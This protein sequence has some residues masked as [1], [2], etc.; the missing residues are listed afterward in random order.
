VL[1]SAITSYGNR[2]VLKPGCNPAEHTIVYLRGTQ[3]Q[4]MDGEHARGMTKHPIAIDPA[5]A[6]ETISA[7]S[8]LRLGKTFT[9]ECN[10]K[11]RDIGSVVPE[12]LTTLLRYHRDSRD[13]GFEP[14][15]WEDE[16]P[17]NTLT[18]PQTEQP[19]HQSDSS[20]TG[21][22]SQQS[23]RSHEPQPSYQQSSTH[24]NTQAYYNAQNSQKPQNYQIPQSYPP[25]SGYYGAPGSQGYQ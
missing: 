15:N 1:H 17:V 25:T 4:Y 7:T 20:Y 21:L 5:T 19:S 10:V 8:R 3:P 24:P 16:E 6:T 13:I 11:V 14:D 2:G 23:T 18:S 12:H 22:Y 9:I